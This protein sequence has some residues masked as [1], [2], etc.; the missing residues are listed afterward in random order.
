MKAAIVPVC[1]LTAPPVDRRHLERHSK[2][3]AGEL[4]PGFN[5]NSA[6]TVLHC[7][8]LAEGSAQP[9]GTLIKTPCGIKRY[10]FCWVVVVLPVVVSHQ[11]AQRG[12]RGDTGSVWTLSGSDPSLRR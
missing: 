5:P 9:L 3:P 11:V 6:L 4:L 8:A 10:S 7:T 1:S 2:C 12:I